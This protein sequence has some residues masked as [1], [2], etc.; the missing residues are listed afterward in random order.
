MVVWNMGGQRFAFGNLA[1][2]QVQLY[3]DNPELAWQQ[4]MD[5]YGKGNPNFA[6]TTLGRFIASRMDEVRNRETIAQG[7]QVARNTANQITWQKG[8]DQR[9]A[10]WE[11]MFAQRTAENN[12]KILAAQKRMQEIREEVTGATGTYPGVKGARVGGVEYNQLAQSI[13]QMQQQNQEKF[14]PGVFAPEPTLT[15]TKYMEQDPNINNYVEQFNQLSSTQRGA[16]P[17]IFKVRREIW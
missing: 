17:G 6:A 15:L 11:S 10:Q 5:F 16:N 9:K 13:K 8:E 7:E 4:L 1:P 2:H 14:T 3:E 12:A